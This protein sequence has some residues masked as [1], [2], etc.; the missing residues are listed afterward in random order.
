[1]AVVVLFTN[2]RAFFSPLA[3]VVLGAVG[4]AA[5]LL[6]LRFR[7]REQTN[8]VY[9]QVWLNALGILL[10]LAALVSDL[11]HLGQQLT[12]TLALGAVTG[13]AISGAMILHAFRKQRTAQK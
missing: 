11:F 13:F 7:R 3:V 12:Q 5:I 6:Q 2:R 1:V 8:H 4:L 10:A 9:S